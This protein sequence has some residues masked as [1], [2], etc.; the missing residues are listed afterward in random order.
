MNN[1]SLKDISLLSILNFK[2]D[3][4]KYHYSNDFLIFNRKRGKEVV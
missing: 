2:Y 4:Y 1:T 3:R